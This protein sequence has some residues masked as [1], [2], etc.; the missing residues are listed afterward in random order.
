MPF[1]PLRSKGQIAVIMVIALPAL[2]AAA[3]LGTDVAL[4]YANWT[5]MQK[6]ADAAALAGA[7]YLPFDTAKAQTTASSW[8]GKNGIQSGEITGTPVAGD[9]LSIT[10]NLSRTVPYFLARAVG[11][12]TGQV[13]VSGTAGIAKNPSNGRGMMPVGLNCPPGNC[14]YTTGTTYQLKANQ[15]GPG[16]WAALALGGTGASVYLN[17]IQSGYNGTLDSSATTEPGNVVGPTGQGI[18]A[19]IAAG[20]AVDP[21][22]PAGSAPLGTAPAYDPRLVVVPMIDSSACTGSNGNGNGNGNGGGGSGTCNGRNTVPIVSYGEMWLLSVTAN[23]NTI[24]AVYLG[25]A[26]PPS[27]GTNASGNYGMMTP[28]LL[29]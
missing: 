28:I 19:R 27:G 12:T 23:N 24:N 16:N 9:S 3:A 29:R 11:L 1:R 13:R 20:A 8:A 2:I 7:N 26:S 5:W 22:I 15:V 21:S 6:A 25:P 10:V 14:A 4:M 17:N 18:N